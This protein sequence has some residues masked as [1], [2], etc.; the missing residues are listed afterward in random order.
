ML[1]VE[2]QRWQ[3]RVS[4]EADPAAAA[5]IALDAHSAR[6]QQTHVAADRAPA[7]SELVGQLTHRDPAPRP[8]R[9]DERIESLSALE[10]A[11]AYAPTPSCCHA[12]K[13]P[14]SIEAHGSD[15]L[16]ARMEGIE[17]IRGKSKWW[18]DNHEIH[19]STAAGP[20]CGQRD[21]R[22]AALFEMDVTFKPTGER[23]QLRE[24][25]LYTVENDKIV[26]EEFWYQVD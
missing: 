9:G 16:P 20:F 4:G 12:P 19:E 1:G 21:D 3:R 18:Y 5:A 2:L 14:E 22:F 17:A 13:L 11:A 8:D 7:D 26:Q 23:T 10:L 6:P 25:A 24:V 15:E